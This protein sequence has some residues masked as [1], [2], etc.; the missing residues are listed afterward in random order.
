MTIRKLEIERFGVTSSKPI[1]MVV[2]TLAPFS[3]QV[4]HSPQPGRYM[5]TSGIIERQAWKGWC[6]FIQHA[7]KRAGSEVGRDIPFGE[8]GEAEP[9][10]SRRQH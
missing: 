6:P 10:P 7:N 2:A 9:G 5:P 1:E 3:D 8:I 4:D